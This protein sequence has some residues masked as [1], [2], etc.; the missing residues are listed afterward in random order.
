MKVAF[1]LILALG[2][3]F[4][5]QFPESRALRIGTDTCCK[6]IK[7]VLE[8]GTPLRNSLVEVRRAKVA[9]PYKGLSVLTWIRDNRVLKT[10]TDAEGKLSVAEL[11]PD[12]FFVDAKNKSNRLQGQIALF[13][14]E[15]RAD[16]VQAVTMYRPTNATQN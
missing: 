5:Q 3:C 4:A 1:V 15:N 9:W 12:L 16:C 8:D 11:K 14:A 7:L 10:R 2:A 13:P 6:N